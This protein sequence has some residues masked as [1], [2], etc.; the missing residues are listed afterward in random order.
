MQKILLQQI[1]VKAKTREKKA[2]TYKSER[3]EGKVKGR[4][5]R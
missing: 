1:L 4:N 5:M 2:R 3:S